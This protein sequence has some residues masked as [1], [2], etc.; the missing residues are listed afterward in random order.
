MRHTSTA[1]LLILLAPALGVAPAGAVELETGD[2]LVVEGDGSGAVFQVDPITG[3]LTPLNA[4][5]PVGGWDAWGIAFDPVHHVVYKGDEQ[6]GWITQL[7]PATGAEA[8][9]SKHGFVPVGSGPVLASADD[10]V[11]EPDGTI[12]VV[13]NTGDLVMFDDPSASLL[14]VD[15]TSGDRSVIASD[16]VGSGPSLDSSFRIGIAV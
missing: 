6:L 14:R 9:I 12:V 11:V 1:V 10:T 13:D 4:G 3:T 2:V 15:R 8:L 16:T 7:D 5:D